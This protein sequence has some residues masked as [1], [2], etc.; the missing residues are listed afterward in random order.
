MPPPADAQSS[1]FSKLLLMQEKHSAAVEAA[2][3]QPFQ[4]HYAEP[5]EE[6]Q[7]ATTLVVET[8][9][10]PTKMLQGEAYKLSSRSMNP[11]FR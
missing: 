6:K 1:F 11:R 8:I 7:V 10:D 4:P 9:D 3:F 2:A 5:E